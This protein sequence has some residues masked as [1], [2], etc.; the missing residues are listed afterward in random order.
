MLLVLSQKNKTFAIFKTLNDHK[1]IYIYIYK[2]VK[3]FCTWGTKKR[4]NHDAMTLNVPKS[5]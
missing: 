3:T 5:G 4:K 1:I 2:P